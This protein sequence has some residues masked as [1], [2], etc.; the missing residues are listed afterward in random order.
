MEERSIPLAK[1]ERAI[2]RDWTQGSLIGN[3][4]SL[5]W[6]MIVGGSLNMMG[7]TIDM[8]W[9]G[10][11]GEAAIAGVGVSGM[12]VMLASSMVM[13]LYMGLRAMVSRFVGSGDAELAQHVAQQSIIV[14]IVF[15]SFLALIGIFFAENMLMV[16]GVDADVIVEGAAYL[17]INFVGMV[18]MSFRNMTESTMQASGD[19]VT[20]M[21]IAVLFRLIH[22]ALCPFLVFGWL[23]FPE[24]GVSGAA[25]TS[26]L[27]QGLGAGIGL[28][29]LVSGRTRMRLTLRNFRID[30]AIIW[31]LVKIGLPAS[32]NAMGRTLGNLVLMWFITPFGTVAVA[33]HTLNQRIEFLLY[34][35]QMGMGQ[36]AG[37]LAGQNL[38]A[39]QPERAKKTG[40]LAAAYLS[41]FILI[42]ITLILLWAEKIVRIFNSDPELVKMASTFLRIAA[43]GYLVLG[44]TAV[45][46][47]CLN[48]VGDTIVPMVI[49]MI[50]MWLLQ[51]VLA[52]FF[53]RYTSLGVFGV[54]WAIVAGTVTAAIAYTTYFHQGR[55]LRKKV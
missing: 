48:G 50:N 14:S 13:G 49:M 27:S 42:V 23:I 18:T 20:P 34:V 2:R 45:F 33:S 22:I 26:V 25:L 40:W 39:Q 4:L 28:W 29:F 12:I 52:F 8:I 53:T 10:K 16:M 37:V 38:G 19:S 1:R 51:V 36:A 32:V 11:L 41:G 21:W 7:P 35:P 24:L 31:R 55:W 54:R 47:Q 30:P 5:A 9:V 3:L 43:S 6:P 46:Q 15:S 17:R 44:L